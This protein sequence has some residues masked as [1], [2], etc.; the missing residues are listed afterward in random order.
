MSIFTLGSAAVLD[1]K[2]SE[3]IFLKHCIIITIIV[4]II[5]I[6]SSSSSSSSS[7]II[8]SDFSFA[9]CFLQKM[10]DKGE[11]TFPEQTGLPYSKKPHSFPGTFYG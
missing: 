10:T 3:N 1:P 4:I 5:I 7:S 2:I 11:K 6:I 9:V 8:E